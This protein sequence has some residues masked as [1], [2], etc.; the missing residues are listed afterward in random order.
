MKMKI[1]LLLSFLIATLSFNV[2]SAT[3]TVYGDSASYDAATTHQIFLIDFNGSPAAYV[4]G[5]TISP[6]A[7]FGSPEASDPTQVLWNSDA[8]SDAGSTISVT[9]VGPV[10]ID[11]TDT[12]VL[13]FSLDFLSAGEQETVELYDSSNNLIASVLAPNAS[14]FFGVVSDTAIDSVIIR[15]GLFANG[16]PDRFFID[17][18][19]V[20]AVVPVPAAFWLFISGLAGL[21]MYGRGKHLK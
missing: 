15:N 6:Y 9:S 21:V 7:I 19:S 18:L 5:S 13:A 2:N 8:L 20:D 14:G 3:V 10:S 4:D 11:F 17:N 12:D 16:N 1:T